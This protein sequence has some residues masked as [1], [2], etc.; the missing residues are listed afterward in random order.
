VLPEAPVLT[1]RRLRL[2]PLGEQHTEALTAAAGADRSSYGWTSVP[3]GGEQVRDYIRQL[4]AA[5][6]TLPFAQVVDG[7]AAGVTRFL[8]FR[9]RAEAA[10]PYAVEIGGTWLAASGQGAGI[11]REAKL[12]LM[13]HAFEV[14]GVGRVDFKTDARNERSRAALSGIGATFEGV[15]RSWQ[16]SHAAGE[17]GA[18]RDSAM[19]SVVAAEWPAVKQRLALRLGS[20][21]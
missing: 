20:C 8:A 14:W 12:L 15:L 13:T 17:E 6:D 1:G 16:P 10:L 4:V 11:N 18:L 9:T 21:G 3:S 19:F 7:R 5:Q 2:E